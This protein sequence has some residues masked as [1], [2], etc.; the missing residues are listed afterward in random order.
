MKV[1]ILDLDGG[2][3]QQ[4]QLLALFRPRI[5][6]LQ[7]W[8]PC[9]RMACSFARFRRFEQDL[10]R[11]FDETGD[12]I[13]EV[14]LLGSGDFHHV[15]LALLRR[16]TE[17]FNL[18]VIDKHPDWMRAIPFLH[19]GTWLAH[20]LHQPM[21]R[22]IF[23]VGGDLDFDN[24]FRWLAP[25]TA[26]QTGKVI[27]FPAV[28][29]FDRGWWRH[30]H[31]HPL[32]QEGPIHATVESLGAL[33]HPFASDLAAHPLVISLDKDVMTE[34][35]A[36]VNWDSGF[37]EF[38]EV[39]SVLQAFLQA[40]QGRVPRLRRGGRLVWGP[41]VRAFAPG[42]SRPGTSAL[43]GRSDRGRPAKRKDEPG[44]AA[45]SG[46]R[47]CSRLQL[48]RKDGSLE[49][50]PVDRDAGREGADGVDLD[51]PFPDLVSTEGE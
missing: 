45:L 48:S 6:S 28:R 2:L 37:L 43:D 7:D 12:S 46:H 24:A 10:A 27:V 19:C 14:V 44:S 35:E 8:G 3:I 5:L 23:H 42:T 41:R 21:V 13:P 33:L 38:T 47:L 50:G 40:A 16:R 15:S 20:V 39:Q 22:R 29:R 4:K 32:R 11:R 17:P 9:L 51:L 31:H 26:L 25:R 34:A 49:R 1:C 18:L 30:I 36:V